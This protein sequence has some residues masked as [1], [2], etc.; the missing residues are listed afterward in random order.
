MPS[1][2][3]LNFNYKVT[4][5]FSWSNQQ[6]HQTPKRDMPPTYLD[7]ETLKSK[8]A[9]NIKSNK[10]LKPTSKKRHLLA[11]IQSNVTDQPYNS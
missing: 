1:Q 11:D 8:N 7:I 9:Q 10:L 6:N 3:P 5:D 2:F 4:K